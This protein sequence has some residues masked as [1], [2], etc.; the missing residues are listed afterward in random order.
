MPDPAPPAAPDSARLPRSDRVLL[1]ID[2]IT[3]LKFPG[4]EGMADAAV[5]AARA[6]AGLKRRLAAQGVP[7][8]YANDNFGLWQ[9]DFHSQ[10]STCL[11]L[12]GAPGEIARLLYPQ[13]EDITLLKPRH[14]AFFASPLEL[15][16]REIGARSLVICGLS[17]DM[18]VQLTA[19]EAFLRGLDCW[20]PGDCSASLTPQAHAGA[21]AYMRDVLRC[22][23]KTATAP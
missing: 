11:G 15:L 1:L 20:V 13:A 22:E 16:L 14:S 19:A 6:T 5:A 2:F 7:T 8:L 21:L 12:P 3:P 18:C 23:V 4:A 9:S 10:V 17:T